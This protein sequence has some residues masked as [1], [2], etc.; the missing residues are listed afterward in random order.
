MS[1]NVVFQVN[2]NQESLSTFLARV[3]SVICVSFDMSLE[4]SWMF[5]CFATIRAYFVLCFDMFDLCVVVL[6]VLSGK[7]HAAMVALKG[8]FVVQPSHV[9]MKEQTIGK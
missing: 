4:C 1:F 3:L 2:L 8:L 5:K 9:A 6:Q 7:H